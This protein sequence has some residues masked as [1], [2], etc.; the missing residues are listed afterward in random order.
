MAVRAQFGRAT[1]RMYGLDRALR[2]AQGPEGLVNQPVLAQLDVGHIAFFK[3][4]NLISHAG[5]GH[6]VAG[7][8]MRVDTDAQDQ[9]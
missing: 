9:W 2:R 1:V 6:G 3:V 5:Q 8:V 4:N 7:Q